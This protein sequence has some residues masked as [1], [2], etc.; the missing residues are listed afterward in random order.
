MESVTTRKAE[1]R[2]YLAELF[3]ARAG[4]ED[5]TLFLLP[6]SGSSSALRLPSSDLDAVAHE[7]VQ[8][9]LEEGASVYLTCCLLTRESSSRVGRGRAEDAAVIP[10]VWVDLDVAGPAHKSSNLPPS[11][12]AGLE[13]LGAMQPLPSLVVDSGHGLY[14]WWLF[15]A[16]IPLD[17]ELRPRAHR[18]VKAGQAALGALA[19]GR[20][21]TVDATADLA[22]VLRLPGTTNW[23]VPGDPRP[24]RILHE[25]GLRY[26]PLEL[27]AAWALYAGPAE[28]HKGPAEPLAERITAGNR[29]NSVASLAGTLRRRNVVEAAAMAAALEHNATV[30]SPPLPEGKVRETVHG[31]YTRYPAGPGPQAAP[32]LN[33]HANGNGHGPATVA[34]A[35]LVRELRPARLVPYSSIKPEPVEFAWE[36]G[37]VKGGLTIIAGDPGKGKGLVCTAIAA[38]MTA[39]AELPGKRPR[40]GEVLWIS[41]EEA[42]ASAIRPR[43]D[44]AGA[45]VER[46][47]KWE[48]E[49]APGR[50]DK[51]F[52]PEDVPEL[53]A[54]LRACP[55]VRLVVLDP[56]LSYMGGGT[57]INQGNEVRD[58]LDP[59]VDVAE[60]YGVSL[61]GIAHISKSELSKVLYRVSNSVAFVAL[62]RSVMAVGELEDKRRVLAHIKANYT[63]PFVPVPFTIVGAEHPAT[64][65]AVGRIV[66]E[67]PDEDIDPARIFEDHSRREKGDEEPTA[68][69]ECAEEIKELL[70]AGPRFVSEAKKELA[71]RGYSKKAIDWAR[72]LAGVETTGGGRGARW[73]LPPLSMGEGCLSNPTPGEVDITE[74]EVRET[75]PHHTKTGDLEL[76]EG[77]A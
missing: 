33:G 8:A 31:I 64:G 46:V 40:P 57:N 77:P 38:A 28:P 75:P 17:L 16:P 15:H 14:G 55:G 24:V 61:L 56:V 68:A 71:N 39:G 10:G 37:I 44:V 72:V 26:D 22:R 74:S 18:L 12:E 21:W 35:G 59:L 45:N 76:E 9:S 1:A 48:I 23:K 29:T 51:F 62:A 63:A 50:V 66:W 53:E 52:K 2:R 36:P 47:H 25:T 58:R 67:E 54:A 20:G 7:A 5:A 3:G 43:L 32:A 4:D 30:C 34:A 41:Y 6:S 70:A 49:R 42:E 19:A 27:E 60:R 13:L 69:M 11:L 73:N 65:Q